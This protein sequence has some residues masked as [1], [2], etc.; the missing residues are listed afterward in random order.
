MTRKSGAS[1][2]GAMSDAGSIPPEWQE[3]L[4]RQGYDPAEA[5]KLADRL[6][7]RT[8]GSFPARHDVFRALWGTRPG[9][10]RA[11]ILGQDP[12]FSEP[13]QAHGLA[14][15]VPVGVPHPPSLR[16]ILN[17]LAVDQ[18]PKWQAPTDGDL[19]AWCD[20]GVL[21]LNTALTVPAGGPPETDLQDWNDFTCAIL[22]VVKSS[23]RPVVFLLWGKKA[24]K[25]AGT[26]RAPHV[27]FINAHPTSRRAKAPK[28]AVDPPFKKAAQIVNKAG[29]NL[30]WIL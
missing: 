9:D 8:G 19:A 26:I 21:L 22:D 10:V 29:G 7:S 20:Q 4:R 5:K 17:A 15:S 11:V 27:A 1:L 12:Y 16:N 3:A 6:S 30:T 14:F 2:P 25:A 23:T 28:L 13:G 18:T 24:E